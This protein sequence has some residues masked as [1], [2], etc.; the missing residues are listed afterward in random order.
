MVPTT[1]LADLSRRLA[2]ITPV[3]LGCSR[4]GTTLCLGVLDPSSDDNAIVA[5]CGS[6]LEPRQQTYAHTVLLASIGS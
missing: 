6:A 2:A 1:R 4:A 5:V 3:I